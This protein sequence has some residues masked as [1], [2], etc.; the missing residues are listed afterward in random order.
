[1]IE[2]FENYCNYLFP[3][4]DTEI[5]QAIK[6]E[7]E[8]IDMTKSPWFML[9]K[10]EVLSQGDILNK[11]PFPYEKDNG[12]KRVYVGKGMVLSN[13]CD[14]QRDP[15]IVIAPLFNM[16]DKIED[17][18]EFSAQTKEN[19]KDN[20]VAAKMGFKNSSL[21]NYFV[22]FSKSVSFNRKVL[23]KGMKTGKIYIEKSLSQFACYMLYIK[24][25]IYYMRVEN[26]EH[27]ESRDRG[28]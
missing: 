9:N 11:L 22:D 3:S 20:I 24:L 18:K 25:T 19:L 21:D 2:F 15:Y 26:H 17:E 13:T 12:D 1:M 27:F 6:K 7:V 28:I 23:L 16:D 8:R 4:V 5:K 14:L 10:L